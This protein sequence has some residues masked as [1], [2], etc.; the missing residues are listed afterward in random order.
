MLKEI[1]KSCP[2]LRESIFVEGRVIE[3]DYWGLQGGIFGSW[4]VC[5]YI[6]SHGRLLTG[7]ERK[8]LDIYEGMKEI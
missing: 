1:Q 2:M 6:Q 3:G 7:F 8:Q 4:F 5:L